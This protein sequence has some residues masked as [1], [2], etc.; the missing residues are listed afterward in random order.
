[1]GQRATGCHSTSA[2]SSCLTRNFLQDKFFQQ[3]L[4]DEEK[5][6]NGQA[7]NDDDPETGYDEYGGYYDEYGG[8]CAQVPKMNSSAW[9]R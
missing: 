5:S 8:T 2:L 9:S 6:A 7:T 1:M 3:I 4:N